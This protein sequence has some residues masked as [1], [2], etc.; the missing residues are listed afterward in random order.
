MFEWIAGTIAGKF[1]S[2][3]FISMLPIVELRAGLPYGI[4]LGL[5]YPLALTAAVIGN[6]FPVPFIII[7]IQRV[8]IW[9]RRHWPKMDSFIT[10]LEAKAHLKGEKV[11]KY[12]PIA[13]LLFVGIPLPGTG[14]WTGS[15]A[16]DLFRIDFKKSMF[17][18]TVG[19]LIA[20]A[21]VTV[22]C[23][24]FPALASQIF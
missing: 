14:A 18:V 11:Q 13:L 5:D 3:F 22:I 15:L 4:A 23:Y 8:F 12:G 6:M 7:F 20:A 21:I 9:L 17:A 24:A 1:I 10:K 19:V 2:T 16:A